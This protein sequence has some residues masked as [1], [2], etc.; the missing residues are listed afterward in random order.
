MS[1][2]QIIKMASA[3]LLEFRRTEWTSLLWAG[4]I[5]RRLTNMNHKEVMQNMMDQEEF[6][7][8]NDWVNW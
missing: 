4:N 6:E 5:M 2:C 8:G 1:L 3:E 7:Q